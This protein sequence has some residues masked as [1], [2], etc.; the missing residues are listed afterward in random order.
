MVS[1]EEKDY[2]RAH[3]NAH[4]NTFIGF[5]PVHVVL[6]KSRAAVA[7][8]PRNNNRENYKRNPLMGLYIK[9]LDAEEVGAIRRTKNGSRLR[10]TRNVDASLPT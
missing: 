1:V 7:R 9:T 3:A 6:T 4:R 8:R 2:R 10:K 5:L